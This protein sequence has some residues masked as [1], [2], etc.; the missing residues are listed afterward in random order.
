[1]SAMGRS[2]GAGDGC[3]NCVFL[4]FVVTKC[5]IFGVKLELRSQLLHSLETDL[6]QFPLLEDGDQHGPSSAQFSELSFNT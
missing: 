4:I 6:R 3:L 2:I 1:M 5:L